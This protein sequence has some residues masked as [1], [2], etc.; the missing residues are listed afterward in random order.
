MDGSSAGSKRCRFT[1]Q[2]EAPG[3]LDILQQKGLADQVDLLEHVKSSHA[4][5]GEG[6]EQTC[7]YDS[8]HTIFLRPAKQT[9]GRAAL[10]VHLSLPV[11]V[12]YIQHHKL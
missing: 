7:L 5:D 6:T 3:L 12:L 2:K 9:A 1:V 11:C 8:L 10:Q 4:Q